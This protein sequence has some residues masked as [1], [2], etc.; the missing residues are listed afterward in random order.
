M[1]IAIFLRP[2]LGT[3]VMILPTKHTK[4]SESLLGLGGVILKMV[5]EPLT[6]DELWEEYQKI[7]N[8]KNYFP[9]YHSFDN[10]VLALNFLFMIGA[11]DLNKEGKIFHATT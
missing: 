10:V 8:S 1:S 11:I 4:L 7:N 5:K 3:I 6:I 9:A 2:R